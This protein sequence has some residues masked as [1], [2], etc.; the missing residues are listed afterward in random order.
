MTTQE[1]RPVNAKE[2]AGIN[3]LRRCNDEITKVKAQVNLNKH[4]CIAIDGYIIFE[5]DYH[6]DGIV[7]YKTPRKETNYEID[8]FPEEYQ[9]EVQKLQKEL[10][11]TKIQV[12]ELY[13]TV[14][15]FNIHIAS[16]EVRLDLLRSNAKEI[17]SNNNME[18]HIINF[19]KTY[20]NFSECLTSD[21]A[22][23]DPEMKTKIKIELN[24]LVQLLEEEIEKYL[25]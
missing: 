16:L 4:Q 9:E 15:S 5:S 2:K 3:N 8:K 25:N 22:Y 24:K 19:F 14:K 13:K 21:L 23:C 17:K 18:K 1:F 20:E 6:P 10:D 12:K 11:L 7:T